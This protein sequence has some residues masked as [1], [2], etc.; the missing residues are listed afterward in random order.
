PRAIPTARQ[1]P[2][3]QKNT[4]SLSG[5]QPGNELLNPQQRKA[6][7]GVINPEVQQQAKV[8]DAF[9]GA[10]QRSVGGSAQQDLAS[11]RAKAKDYV[12]ISSNDDD[13]VFAPN[14]KEHMSKADFYLDEKGKPTE[15]QGPRAGIYHDT[16]IYTTDDKG[17]FVPF[18]NNPWSDAVP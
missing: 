4:P 14:N 8:R 3:E 1:N 2:A 9:V 6:L 11:A 10:E 12:V 7:E 13:P 17:A 5:T 16:I 15:L 18:A